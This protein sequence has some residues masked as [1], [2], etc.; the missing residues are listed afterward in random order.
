[1]LSFNDIEQLL[2]TS[3][4][5]GRGEGDERCWIRTTYA[6]TVVY[7][8]DALGGAL[9]R[10][11]YA[12][13]ESGVVT[14][15]E[16]EAVIA[17]SE[18]AP[19]RPA[20][21]SV[22][23]G[24]GVP[25]KLF[26]LG[27]W[28]ASGSF[29]GFSLN[30]EQADAWIADSSPL[31]AAIE[32]LST[33]FTEKDKFA[34]GQFDSFSRKGSEIFGMFRPKEWLKSALEG[35]G[36][37]PVSMSWDPRIMRPDEVSFVKNPRISDAKLLAAFSEQGESRKSPL[38]KR[39]WINQKIRDI[40]A[41]FSGAEP[42][43]E[44]VPSLLAEPSSALQELQ[45]RFSN[46]STELASLR[47]QLTSANATIA[48]F[49]T[50]AAA[51]AATTFA[52]GLQREGKISK[53]DHAAWVAR[54]SRALTDDNG[55][56]VKFSAAGTLE[57]G[58]RVADL[59]KQA[60]GLAKLAVFGGEARVEFSNLGGSDEDLPISADVFPVKGGAK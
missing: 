28:P 39:S 60:E 57:E 44:D 52:D 7:S 37:V 1:M 56:S 12:V 16:P 53:A 47:A 26:E 19:V 49:S 35:V 58:E 14:L 43:E 25:V 51:S 5:A 34:L 15:G 18:Y 8:D 42:I 10:R 24:A 23:V 46:Q 36:S 59:R 9:Y 45:A 4:N 13:S 29:P 11:T 17:K 31:P 50:S 38:M 3:L 30:A 32:H 41:T 22:E 48:T 20:S 6:D 27:S 55:G 21:F 2:R 33:V 54:F 40:V